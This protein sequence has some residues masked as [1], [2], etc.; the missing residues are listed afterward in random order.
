MINDLWYKNAV[1]YCLSVDAYMDA[2]GDGTGDFPGLIASPRLPARTRR[3]RDL[4]D[5]V[6]NIALQGRRLRH[7]RLLQCRSS[8]RHAGRFHRVYSRRKTTRHPCLDR[9]GSEPYL[10]SAPLVQ[11]GALRSKFEISALV[12]LVEEETGA[13]KSGNGFSRRT[14]NDVELRSR[15][16]SVVFSSVLRFPTRS[17]H[18]KSRGPS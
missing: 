11:A 8:I 14:K 9:S 17:Q 3:D 1:I 10:R 13:L 16:Q 6:S 18:L 4:A 2:N 7:R 12:R 5:A 15:S